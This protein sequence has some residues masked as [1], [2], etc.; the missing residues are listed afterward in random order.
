M[1]GD[2]SLTDNLSTISSSQQQPNTIS[3]IAAERTAQWA[4]ENG[5]HNNT[6]SLSPSSSVDKEKQHDEVSNSEGEPATKKEK[7]EDGNVETCISTTE[8]SSLD[9][10]GPSRSQEGQASS[11]D[12]KSPEQTTQASQSDSDSQQQEQQ[13]PP[14]TE[15]MYPLLKVQVNEENFH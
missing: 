2:H 9:D 1:N 4:A 3:N 5:N 14:T 12:L 7:L 15:G 8:S 11:E 10:E 13:T 6:E